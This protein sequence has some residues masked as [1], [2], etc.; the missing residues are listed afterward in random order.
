MNGSLKC[1][2][3]DWKFNLSIWQRGLL[4]LKTLTVPCQKQSGQ[5]ARV[6][7]LE[8]SNEY[9]LSTCLSW[10]KSNYSCWAQSIILLVQ[11]VLFSGAG[12]LGCNVARLLLAW[13]VQNIMLVDHG[14]VSYSNPVRQSL[15]V[16]DDAMGGSSNKA[17][18]AAAHLK[19]INPSCE[20]LYSD[21]SIPMPGHP[22]AEI[23]KEEVMWLGGGAIVVAR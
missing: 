7:K 22:I 2:W 10:I 6:I 3:T 15:F 18:R 9:Y 16:F 11:I 14:R 19:S 4:V 21:I 12:T 17:E 5:I 8:N 23:E 20:I 1:Y 13:G